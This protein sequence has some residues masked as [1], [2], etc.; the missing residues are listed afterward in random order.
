M[1]MNTTVDAKGSKSVPVKTIDHEKLRIIMMLSVLDDGKKQAPFFI[2]LK[3]TNLL[4]KAE[5][6]LHLNVRKKDE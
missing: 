1:P 6:Q 5:V 4:Q 3:R 2:I